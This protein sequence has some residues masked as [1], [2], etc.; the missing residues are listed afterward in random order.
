MSKVI[1]MRGLPG[2]GKSYVADR[3]N[4]N[5][6]QPDSVTTIVSADHFHTDENGDYNYDPA[7]AGDAHAQCFERFVIALENADDLVIVD[8]TNTLLL[9]IAPYVAFAR[10]NDAET[11]IIHVMCPIRVAYDRNTHGVPFDIIEKMWART[12]DIPE[13]WPK[14][15]VVRFEEV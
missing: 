10:L 15:T 12:E 13:F 6:D 2:S 11:E 5:E 9:E 14:E 7:N 3:I 4:L 8:N 1:I